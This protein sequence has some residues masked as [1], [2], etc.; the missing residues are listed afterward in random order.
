MQQVP[1]CQWQA[2]L[3]LQPNALNPLAGVITE[4]ISEN[5]L[6]RL[7]LWLAGNQG[8]DCGNSMRGLQN[9]S[10]ACPPANFKLLD[11]YLKYFI[12]SGFLDVPGLGALPREA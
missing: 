10:M 11:T 3:K 12:Q 8:F 9:S 4:M 2:A 1:Y 7:E 5:R 6:T